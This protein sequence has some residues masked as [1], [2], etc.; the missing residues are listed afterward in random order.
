[1]HTQN[2][3]KIRRKRC[4][5]KRPTVGW[6]RQLRVIRKPLMMKNPA[7]ARPPKDSCVWLQSYSGS[8]LSPKPPSG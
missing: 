3:G 5:R 4:H 2:A 8:V 1:M 6:L 7:T